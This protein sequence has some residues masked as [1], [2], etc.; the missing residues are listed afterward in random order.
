MSF[1]SEPRAFDTMLGV[2][3][4]RGAWQQTFGSLVRDAGSGDLKHPAGYMFHD[5]PEVDGQVP[6]DVF[7]ISEMDRWG[8]EAGLLPVTFAEDDLGRDAVQKHPDR[9]YGSFAVDPN[10]GMD[11][12]RALKR[13]VAELGVR[14]AAC[15]PSGTNPQIAINDPLMYPLY[16]AC[17]E[18][19]IPIFVNTGVPGPRFPML[20]QHVEHLDEVC[21]DF[22]E[23][24]IVGRHGGEPWT[25]LF[26]KLMLK[27]PGLHYSTSAFAPKHYPRA[28]IDY[29]NSRGAEKVMYAGYF[30]MGLSLQRI[31]T[32]LPAVPLKDDRWEPFLRGNA[33]R[34]LKLDS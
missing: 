30:P 11:D 33:R 22:P 28:I 19:D 16:A 7:M 27:W 13:A 15:F 29:A 17:V 3:S 31:F 21:Y 32:E 8:V 24:V 10:N 4:N 20:V 12:V 34:I 25:E 18:L 23:L 6:Y 26:V 9:L 2:P 14:A 5:L 1:P